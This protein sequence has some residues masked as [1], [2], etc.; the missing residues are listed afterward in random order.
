V[1]RRRGDGGQAAVELALVLPFVCLLLLALVQ[2]GLV[3]HSQLLVVHAAREGVRAAAVDPHPGAAGIAI[4]ASTPLD[5]ARLDG[6]VDERPDGRVEVVV[7]YDMPTD[8]PLV[9]A[10]IGDIELSA[11]A[12]MRVEHDG[13]G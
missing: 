11:S 4:A 12:V 13:S 3:V 10:L 9:G 7:T 1:T 2:I 6:D 5:L 8:V